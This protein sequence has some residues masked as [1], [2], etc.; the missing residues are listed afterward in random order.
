MA[1]SAA[2]VEG[3][4]NDPSQMRKRM[5]RSFD[6]GAREPHAGSTSD[7]GDRPSLASTEA[8]RWASV[9]GAS[10]SPYASRLR[11]RSTITTPAKH[12]APRFGR[13]IA[14]ALESR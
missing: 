5:N 7:A 1:A 2:R 4:C 9:T 12:E 8:T 11:P 10:K 6:T 3:K 13:T 14:F